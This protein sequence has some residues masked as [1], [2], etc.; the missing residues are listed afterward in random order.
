MRIAQ[1]IKPLKLNLLGNKSSVAISEGW[2]GDLDQVI[3]VDDK[4]VSMTVLDALGHHYTPEN[5]RLT[6]A[7]DRRSVS[8]SPA[9]KPQSQE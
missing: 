4:G 3:G 9:S 5:F 1:C 6:A 7:A 8:E 2:Q